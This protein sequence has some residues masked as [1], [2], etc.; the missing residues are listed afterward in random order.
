MVLNF[1]QAL[2]GGV[3][4]CFTCILSS[5][6]EF[7]PIVFVPSTFLHHISP[8]QYPQV[9]NFRYSE[10]PCLQVSV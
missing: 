8:A 7:F 3:S 10:V 2:L 9:S 1:H 4:L 5:D 6:F